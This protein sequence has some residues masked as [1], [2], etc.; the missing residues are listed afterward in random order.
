MFALFVLFLLLL[1]VFCWCGRKLSQRLWPP[2]HFQLRV[3]PYQAAPH[4]NVVFLHTE[5]MQLYQWQQEAK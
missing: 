5:S 2:R 4:E 1:K 3:V